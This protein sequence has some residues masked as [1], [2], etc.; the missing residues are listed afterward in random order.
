M[1]TGSRWFVATASPRY[2]GDEGTLA[3]LVPVII[4]K[5]LGFLTCHLKAL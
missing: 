1:T 5:A 2:M 3:Y 4:H